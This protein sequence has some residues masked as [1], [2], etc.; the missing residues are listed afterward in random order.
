MFLVWKTLNFNEKLK[1]ENKG[2]YM[3]FA[4]KQ[5]P[6]TGDRSPNDNLNCQQQHCEKKKNWKEK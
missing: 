2:M 3:W 4:V 6:L 5:N 1:M